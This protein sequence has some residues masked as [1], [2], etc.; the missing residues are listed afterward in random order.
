[1]AVPALA[2]NPLVGELINTK[3]NEIVGDKFTANNKN[4]A[5]V[6]ENGATLVTDS[7]GGWKIVAGDATGTMQ[8][9]IKIGNEHR[10]VTIDLAD[11]DFYLGEG[12]G[13]DGINMVWINVVADDDGMGTFAGG[14]EC[15]PGDKVTTKEPTC[16]E[17]GAWE[18]RC[19]VCDEVTS[20]GTI[21]ALVCIP[22]ARIDIVIVACGVAGAWK[23]ECT[24]CGDVLES[25]VIAA[26]G[27]D[28]GEWFEDEAATCEE[29]GVS[30]RVCEREGCE[31][32][33]TEAIEELGHDYIPDTTKPTCTTGGYTTF[34]CS[35]CEDEYVADEV[36][37]FGHSYAAAVTAPT[38]TEAGFTTY[39]CS[40]CGDVQVNMEEGDAVAAL[41]HD[42][43]RVETPM[44]HEADGF[45]TYTCKVCGDVQ[46][47]LQ[48]GDHVD[49]VPRNWEVKEVIAPTCTEKGYTVY[50]D[51]FWNLERNGS[52]VAANGHTA[53]ERNVTLAAT[54][55]TK[56][57]W[58]IRCEVCDELLE[59][60]IIDELK[61]VGAATTAKDFTAI[62]ETAKNSRVWALTFNVTVT[63]AELTL[64]GE[65]TEVVEYTI[66]LNGNNAN[67]DGKFTF[68]A[69]HDLVGKTLTYDI[70]GNGSN[71]KAFSIR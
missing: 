65:H 60:G 4:P 30:K 61:I 1:M 17:K 47:N 48:D 13:K 18:I 58:E 41:G 34:T 10:V 46:I 9:T 12:S 14:H 31:H 19:T 8:V 49:S 22:G 71:I 6:L 59:S 40:V 28:M 53:G 16:T 39:T 21:A 35:R 66:M 2:S 45:A 52:F 37:A 27:H 29:E 11:G 44:T 70:K 69:G 43:D 67:L 15:V 68:G 56:G 57:A 20:S 25:G 3:N 54:R 62:R 63:L 24:V 36:A 55:T 5:V 42:Y 26:L 64:E 32:Y 50:K 51:N 38:C 7:K 33:E 23:V